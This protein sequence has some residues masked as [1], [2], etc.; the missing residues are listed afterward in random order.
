MDKGA[1]AQLYTVPQ[2]RQIEQAAVEAGLSGASLMERAGGA[3]FS[4]LRRRSPGARRLALVCGPGNNGGDGFVI[5]RLARAAG[6]E[7]QVYMLGDPLALKSEAAKAWR[8]M[9]GAGVI[10]Q[11]W[12]PAQAPDLIVDAL[13]GTGLQRPPGGRM[14]EAIA[15]MND[16]GAPVVAVDIPSG[17]NADTGSVLGTAVRAAVTV[18]FL[19]MKL[20]LLT[21][22]GPEY[23]GDIVLADL[24]ISPDARG[25]IAP[26]ALIMGDEM[27]AQLLPRR[28]R[29][30]HKGMYGHVLVVGGEDGMGG[31]ARMAGEAAARAGAGLVS[32]A[33]RA[34]NVAAVIADRPELMAKPVESAEAFEPLLAGASV[35]VIGPGL[36]QSDWAQALWARTLEWEGPKVVDADA[37]HLLARRPSRRDD[38]ILTPH[39][40]EAGR[41]LGVDTRAIQND[42]PGTA[43]E[44]QRRLGGIVALKGAGTL[45][46]AGKAPL[47]VC[48][49]GNAGMASGGMGDVLSG[50]V[51]GLLAQGVPLHE[52]CVLGV[53]LHARAGDLAAGAGERGMLAS[54]LF[55]WLRALVNP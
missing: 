6:L 9:L 24:G 50:V 36:G 8:E 25:M 4:H 12:P 34:G 52:A 20:G 38:W 33:V 42:R 55:P 18:T 49:A 14:A 30:A 3:V 54:D 44:L 23:A 19:G 1:S 40:G 22:A 5:A 48:T 51:G 15:W 31:A 10:P 47:Q 41:L 53:Y 2:I 32:V 29:V 7:P 27:R 17:L 13:F 21:G 28:S 46:C 16:G 35:V 39:P 43:R 45:V 37:L 26:Q 11:V